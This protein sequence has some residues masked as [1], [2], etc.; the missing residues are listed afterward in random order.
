MATGSKKV[1]YAALAGN[2]LIAVTKFVAPFVLVAFGWQMVAV[3]W[4]SALAIMAARQR[5]YL[6][7]KA[8]AELTAMMAV[9]DGKD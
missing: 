5:G 2:A 9:E 4:A 1:I 8:E 3:V 7:A 6:D